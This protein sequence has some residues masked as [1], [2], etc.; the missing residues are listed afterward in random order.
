MLW[1]Y[2]HAHL[3]FVLYSTAFFVSLLCSHI[4][5]RPSYTS[6]GEQNRVCITVKEICGACNC[7][8][9]DTSVQHCFDASVPKCMSYV[10][11][12]TTLGRVGT[13]VGT[14]WLRMWE[15]HPSVLH[16]DHLVP[17]DT[18][19]HT[20]R[21][22]YAPKGSTVQELSGHYGM[23]TTHFANLNRYAYDCVYG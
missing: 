15:F 10:R 21:L 16:P 7:A 11:Q 2:I 17:H 14:D 13:A 19:L 6:G 5:Y 9:G 20:G 8:N 18:L 12:D 4:S 23:S 22:V 3:M 1:S